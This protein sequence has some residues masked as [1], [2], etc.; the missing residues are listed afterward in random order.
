MCGS[1]AMHQA[2]AG[3][4][5]SATVQALEKSVEAGGALD[6]YEVEGPDRAELLQDLGEFQLATVGPAAPSECA[7]FA[8]LASPDPACQAYCLWLCHSLGERL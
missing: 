2:G 4:A 7:A 6:K 1:S 5:R 8:L 3:R